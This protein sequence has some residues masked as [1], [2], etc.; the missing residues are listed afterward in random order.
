[1]NK[2]IGMAAA[3]LVLAPNAAFAGHGKAGLWTVTST[4]DMAMAMPP[5]VAAQMKQAGMTMP[6]PAP[7][8]SRMCMSQSDVDS[9]KPPQ[10]DPN[11]SGCD[12][13]L[14]KASAS[15]IE[16][17][18]TCSGKMKGTGHMQIAYSAP[19]HYSG[20]YSFKGTVEGNP[21]SMST[22]FKGDW[23]KADCGAVKPYKLR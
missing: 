13:K 23:V 3:M 2:V 10:M 7:I 18:M 15:A 9:D 8:T 22:S 20:S 6:K 14:I 11:A 19:E 5:E 16:A 17:Q 4:T 12:T 21:T 1:M